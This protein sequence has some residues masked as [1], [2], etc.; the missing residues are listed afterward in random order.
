MITIA[1]TYQFNMYGLP[2]LSM[3]CGYSASGLPIGMTIAGPRFT[4][5]RILALAAA[6]EK[7][8]NWHTRYP[9]LSE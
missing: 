1:N 3:T 5:G 6:Y 2:A 9:P 4:E 7:V 8:T